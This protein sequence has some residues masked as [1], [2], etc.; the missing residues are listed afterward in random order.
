MDG[1]KKIPHKAVILVRAEVMEVMHDGRVTGVPLENHSKLYEVV[2]QSR[3][4]CSEKVLKFIEGINR[5][6]EEQRK[7]DDG[8]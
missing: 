4:E 1:I 7:T 2:G 6:V 3:Q 5:N 8:N